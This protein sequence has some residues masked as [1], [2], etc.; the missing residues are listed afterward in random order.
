MVVRIRFRATSLGFEVEKL[1]RGQ[2]VFPCHFLFKSL[3]STHLSCEAGTVD[4]PVS[5]LPVEKGPLHMF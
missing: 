5:G 2:L 4:L 3:Y 1:P